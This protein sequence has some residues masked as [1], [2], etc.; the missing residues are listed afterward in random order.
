MRDKCITHAFLCF[1]AFLGVAKAS[2]H[3]EPTELIVLLD[4]A[5]Y[6]RHEVIASVNATHRTPRQ[7]Q[8]AASLANPVS[9]RRTVRE[10]PDEE[11]GLANLLEA[12]GQM[13]RLAS[14]LT[15][16]YPTS[17]AAE[18][19][20][21][22]LSSDPA[23]LYVQLNDT[24][25]PSSLPA[26]E[27]V[28]PNASTLDW[29][30]GPDLTYQWSIYDND[31]G[32]QQAYDV[33]RG[34][35]NIGVVDFGI[36]ANPIHPDLSEN[37]RPQLSMDFSGDVT[38]SYGMEP[39]AYIVDEKFHT[40]VKYFGHGTHVAG[41][42][43]ATSR[44]PSDPYSLNSSAQGG[45]GVCQ[46]CSL[47]IS[48][49]SGHS[50]DGFPT[51]GAMVE[52]IYHALDMGVQVINISFSD[53][54]T[55][56]SPDPNGTDSQPYCDVLGVAETYDVA[57]VAASGNNN[58]P[59]VIGFPARQPTV[60]PVGGIQG[61][62]AIW[63]NDIVVDGTPPDRGQYAFLGS[64]GSVNEF[65]VRGVLAPAKDI[66]STVYT[67]E[68]WN[69]GARCGDTPSW[70]GTFFT[71]FDIYG[72]NAG[73][74]YGGCT[75]TSMATAHV[76][77]IIGLVRSVNPM[78]PLGSW[79]TLTNCSSNLAKQSIRAA[80][81]CGASKYS[82]P[83]N[84]EGRGI[85]NASHSV[86]SALLSN[87]NQRTPLFAFANAAGKTFYTTF[88][89]VARAYLKNTLWPK[90]WGAFPKKSPVRR[91]IGDIVYRQDNT[92][93]YFPG[94]PPDK[95]SPESSDYVV[96]KAEIEIL[97]THNPPNS[98]IELVPLYR[99]G[100]SNVSYANDW[101]YTTKNSELS[102]FQQNGYKIAG[103]EGYLYPSTMSQPA[104]TEKIYRVSL[105][106]T[107]KGDYV[108]IPQ[109]LVSQPQYS[110]NYQGVLLG[111][112]YRH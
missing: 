16:E 33:T 49:A 85:V 63:K 107:G 67:G 88:P 69:P 76:S 93:Y 82:S 68:D 42:I 75:G 34:N 36:Q 73:A 4:P 56:S 84:L 51:V 38:L 3:P 25:T 94:L 1:L 108:V 23:V 7:L 90:E 100:R 103:I 41:I 66:V 72:S 9:A 45:A 24:V 19:A 101:T 26:D 74:G 70:L 28:S 40:D 112:A 79:P 6:S 87:T 18:Q 30:G 50:V 98:N 80:V 71:G 97:A 89:Q 95:N 32:L 27:L 35:A 110:P 77:G 31:T 102:M 39:P 86:N 59:Y 47:I 60:F 29:D 81:V 65:K 57:V 11:Y 61:D 2:G 104:G 111:Y 91:T 21:R 12:N 106:S 52:G 96:A 43:A 54:K 14:Y 62:G 53:S 10:A 8:V 55:C 20:R 64:N 46:K 17:Q 37:F 5:A 15:I 78:L 13:A 22:R 105:K 109:S 44:D 83:T 48:K 99:L 92:E 58:N